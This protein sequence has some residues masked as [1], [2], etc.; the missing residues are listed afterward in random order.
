M[1]NQFMTDSE[2]AR[3]TESVFEEYGQLIEHLLS[4]QNLAICGCDLSVGL[5]CDDCQMESLLHRLDRL[6]RTMRGMARRK[7]EVEA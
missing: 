6:N 2:I 5:V 3:A 4:A 1:N 7:R